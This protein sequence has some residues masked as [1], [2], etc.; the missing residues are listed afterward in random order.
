MPG[1]AITKTQGPVPA[2]SGGLISYGAGAPTHSAPKGSIYLRSDGS[3]TGTRLYT[4][5][6]GS[7]TWAAVPAAGDVLGTTT[8]DSA[9]AGYIS[10]YLSS[11]VASG[12]AVS[13]TTNTDTNVTSLA[14]TAGDWDVSGQIAFTPAATTS[15]TI[16][17]GGINT[18]SAT[19]PLAGVV[20]N[21]FFA[22]QQ[23][24]FVPA[25]G[26]I[27]ENIAPARISLASPTTIYLVTRATFTVAALTAYGYIGAR[28][29]R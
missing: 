26:P 7:T 15:I 23:P 27:C 19:M 4:N 24:A 9:A 20:G 5:T 14:L 6:D 18:V 11:A 22:I 1:Q 25:G 17:R 2:F 28:R 21:G 10:E 3:T 29:A 12:S 8:N 13:L 16:L